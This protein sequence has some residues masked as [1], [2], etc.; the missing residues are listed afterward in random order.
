MSSRRTID[1]PDESPTRLIPRLVR[2]SDFPLNLPIILKAGL[3][4]GSFR[5][6]HFF[7][8]EI[9]TPWGFAVWKTFPPLVMSFK[10]PCFLRAP[11]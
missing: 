7:S 9:L 11:C 5:K 1:P 4:I 10:A 3:F 6:T 2:L 8:D